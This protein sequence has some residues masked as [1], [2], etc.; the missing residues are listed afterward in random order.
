MVKMAYTQ[1][2]LLLR[3]FPVLL[4]IVLISFYYI[5]FQLY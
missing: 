2:I 5:L 4:A 3:L 1:E